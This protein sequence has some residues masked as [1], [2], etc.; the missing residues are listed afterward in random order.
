MGEMVLPLTLVH[1]HHPGLGNNL[2]MALVT[3]TAN[4]QATLNKKG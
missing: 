4:V 2:D 3:K 1:D